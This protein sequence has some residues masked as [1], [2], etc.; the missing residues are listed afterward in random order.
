ML[1]SGS[2]YSFF[3]TFLEI[4]FYL[5]SGKIGSS[6]VS[7]FRLTLLKIIYFLDPFPSYKIISKQLIP[8]ANWFSLR[9]KMRVASTLDSFYKVRGSSPAI[10]Y[11]TNNPKSNSCSNINTFGNLVENR[12]GI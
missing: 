10:P 6:R 8:Y 2:N 4:S 11:L 3:L 9:S 7:L 1:S 12:I 5:S